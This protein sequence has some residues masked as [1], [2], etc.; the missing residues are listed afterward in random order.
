MNDQLTYTKD[1]SGHTVWRNARKIGRVEPVMRGRSGSG[2]EVRYRAIGPDNRPLG[3]CRSMSEAG[4]M[5]SRHYEER[6]GPQ[7]P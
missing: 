4:Q 2:V 7:A 3:T 6:G 1:R 5:V